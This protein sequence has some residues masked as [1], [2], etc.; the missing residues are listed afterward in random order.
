[1][2]NIMYHFVGCD[3]NLKGIS[4][5]NFKAQLDSLKK[6]YSKDELAITFDHG[7]IDHLEFAAPE[8][9]KR[10]LQ[11]IFFILTMVPEEH[12]V[13]TIDKQRFLEA[14]FRMELARMLCAELHIH[15][16]P[17]EAEEYLS[18]FS[19]Y[20]IEE[21]YIRYLRDKI[22]AREA[23]DGFI[24]KYFKQA[25]GDEKSFASK[26]YLSW[27]HIVQLHKRGHV[28]GSHSHYHD[29]DKNDYAR[30][31]NLIE[32][33]IKEKV[34]YVSYPNGVKRISDEDLKILGITK[35]Y[36]STENGSSEPYRIARIDC[37]NE[38]LPLQI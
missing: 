8:L 3:E 25:F 9:E 34:Q 32:E 14:T 20:S 22:I 10:G 27:E 18:D 30:S 33:K 12:R 15:Y 16:D 35:A 1:M 37:N 5:E 4:L 2:P 26:K 21:R 24:E 29:G 7:T 11:G 13:V 36:I 28:I 23:Y 38:P 19:F 17:R 31:I 6:A